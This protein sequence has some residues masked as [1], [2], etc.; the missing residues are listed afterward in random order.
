[1]CETNS[2]INGAT[3]LEEINK[4]TSSSSPS[5]DGRDCQLDI[6][7]CEEFSGLDLMVSIRTELRSLKVQK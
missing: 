1:M 5:Y 3:S 4:H 2:N 7:D 6:E